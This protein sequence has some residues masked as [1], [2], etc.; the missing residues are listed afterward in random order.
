MRLGSV[1]PGVNIRAIREAAQ[2]YFNGLPTREE[3]L[4][5]ATLRMALSGLQR[6]RGLTP[7]PREQTAF[8]DHLE[9]SA[10][11]LLLGW[12]LRQFI[13]LVYDPTRPVGD[14]KTIIRQAA[15]LRDQL[16]EW[17]ECLQNNI[18]AWGYAGHRSDQEDRA[19]WRR[20]AESFRPLWGRVRRRPSRRDWLLILR[21]F[22]QDF[23]GAPVL[24]VSLT[25]GAAQKTVLEGS[26][27]PL[28]IVHG[29]M[30]GHYDLFVPFVSARAPDGVILEGFGCGG[31]GVV[32]VE[33]KNSSLN[34]LPA[35]VR[36]VRG[37][38][39]HAEAVLQ[40]DS[41]WAYLGCAD[42]AAAM[43]QPKL[44][45]QRGRLWISLKRSR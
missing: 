38:V 37:P 42:I 27:K 32:F 29:R 28:G 35:A 11:M 22:L 1:R 3:R 14:R 18:Q 45:E 40:D 33:A 43:R 8:L 9:W 26:Y 25:F 13:P 5:H 44:E 10:R 19:A 6:Q 23:Y 12:Q 17:L 15:T 20:L 16:S 34:L 30:G 21:L 41:S 2:P 7:P 36:A 39:T 31:Q 24:K 4:E